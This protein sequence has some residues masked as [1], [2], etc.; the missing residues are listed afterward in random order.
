MAPRPCVDG[1]GRAWT[2]WQVAQ[3]DQL[4]ENAGQEPLNSVYYKDEGDQ[5][6]PHCD[7]ECYGGPYIKGAR[8]THAPACCP[9]APTTV[10]P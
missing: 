8:A 9:E 10:T 5:Y 4:I 7:G 3:Y 2:S 6:R 1:R